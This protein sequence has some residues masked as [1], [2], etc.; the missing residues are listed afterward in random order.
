MGQDGAL[1]G[2]I[3]NGLDA[4]HDGFGMGLSDA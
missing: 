1:T 3:L 2:S 4:T